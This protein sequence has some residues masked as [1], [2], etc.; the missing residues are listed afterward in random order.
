MYKMLLL[1]AL[2]HCEV[3]ELFVKFCWIS[4][5]AWALDPTCCSGP[6]HAHDSY[7]S[8]L[9]IKISVRIINENLIIEIYEFF[10]E[11]F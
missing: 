9:K 5:K 7:E 10:L 8:I 1:T 2:N 3:M 6:L 11:F 4:G